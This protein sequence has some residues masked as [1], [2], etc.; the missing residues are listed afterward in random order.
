MM[1]FLLFFPPLFFS[2]PFTM[3]AVEKEECLCLCLVY[4]IV[5]IIDIYIYTHVKYYSIIGYRP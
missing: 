4:T 2:L 5:Y 1:N 3:V